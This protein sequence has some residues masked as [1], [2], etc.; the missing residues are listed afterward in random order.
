MGRLM[1]RSRR[2]QLG[3]D[4]HNNP[5]KNYNARAAL[6]ARGLKPRDS[7]GSGGRSGG[8][9]AAAVAVAA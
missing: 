6:G 1:G 4:G 8:K 9:W 2:S 7:V 5:L 3:A